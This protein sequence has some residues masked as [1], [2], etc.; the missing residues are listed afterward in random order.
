MMMKQL[1]QPISKPYIQMP[2]LFERS[3]VEIVII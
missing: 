2:S 3:H 1:P